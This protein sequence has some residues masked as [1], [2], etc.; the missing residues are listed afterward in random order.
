M[1][2]KKF[3]ALSIIERANEGSSKNPNSNGDIH[4]L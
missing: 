1:E 3:T 2:N 4:A